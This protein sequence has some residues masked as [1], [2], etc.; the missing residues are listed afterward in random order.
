MRYII[1]FILILLTFSCK[2]KES[3]R[4]SEK[5]RENVLIRVNDTLLSGF[6]LK[7]IPVDFNSISHYD[8]ILVNDPKT[9]SELRIWKNKYGELEAEC[10][11]K[12]K[13]IQKVRV[14]KDKEKSTEKT[15]EV[16]KTLYKYDKWTFIP[17]GVILAYIAFKV[18]RRRLF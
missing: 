2:I 17:W 7:A 8:T 10:E 6:D 14:E 1:P 15:K 18:L 16:I 11:Q 3:V 4:E 5:V 12:D 13:L 9:K